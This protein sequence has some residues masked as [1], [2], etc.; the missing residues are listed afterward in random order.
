M[1]HAKFGEGTIV[2]MEGSGE[3]SRFGSGIPGPGVLMAGS[4]SRPAGNG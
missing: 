2:N 4:G 3:H 1:R